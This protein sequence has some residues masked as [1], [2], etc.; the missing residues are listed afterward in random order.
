M[1]KE[2]SK[3]NLAQRI[4]SVMSEVK[5][6]IKGAKVSITS[7]ASYKAVSHDDV[8]ALL[9]D[10]VTE[11]GI[12]VIPDM[13]SCDLDVITSEKSYQGNVT[14]ST[15]YLAKVWASVTF[16]N[17]DDPN[18]K[19]T[20]KCF[21]YAIDSGDKAVGKAYSMA[22]KYCY[23]KTFMLESLDDEESRDEERKLPPPTPPKK[24]TPVFIPPLPKPVTKPS[25]TLDETKKEETKQANNDNVQTETKPQANG[26]PASQAQK[27]TL[28]KLN[29]LFNDDIT[30]DHASKLIKDAYS[31]K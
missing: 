14:K 24:D 1:S 11:A 22:V 7:T 25:F 30:M 27:S 23:L 15:H 16:I 9:H 20:T 3:K 6:V 28:K 21:S 18:D 8:T 13:G 10:P 29:I 2:Q 19:L 31:I 17:I 26:K 5:S 12:I 4:N